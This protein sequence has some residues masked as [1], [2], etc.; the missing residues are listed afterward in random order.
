MAYNE[1]LHHAARRLYLMCRTP[2]EIADELSVPRRT[3]YSWVSKFNWAEQLQEFGLLESIDRRIQS[4]LTVNDKNSLQMKELELLIDRH[5]KLL[6]ARI[7]IQE[8]KES[9]APNA[10]AQP[11]HE[12]RERSKKKGRTHKNDVSHLTEADFQKGLDML[13]PFQRYVVDNR[14]QR[15]R[16]ILKSRQIGMTFTL[17]FEALMDA[18]LSGDPCIFLS[19]SRAQAEVF[20]TYIV[21]LA[22]QLFE[23]ELKGNPIELHT[24]KGKS[25]LRFLGTN[26]NT[27]HSYSGHLYTDEYFWIRSF[28]KIKKVSSGIATHKHWRLT[29]FSTPSS[30]EHEAYGFWTGDDWKG[31]DPK[32]K[33]I[34]F[35]SIEDYRDGGRLCP[36]GQWRYVITIEDAVAQGFDLV[37]IDTL[38]NE[39]S[40]LEY[41]NL[42]MCVFVSSK[43]AIF[44]FKKV[45]RCM[46]D[47]TLWPD[48]NAAASRPFADKEV[49]I[50]YDPSRT[51]DPASLVVVAPPTTPKK[52]FRLLKRTRLKGMSYKYQAAEIIKLCS[53]YNVRYIGIDTTGLGSAVYEIVY[54]K[55]P[56]ITHAIHYNVET[57][58][59]LVFKMVDLVDEK[60]IF[61]DADYKDISLSFL[62]IRRIVTRSGGSVTF[63]ANRTKDTGH[64]DDFFALAHACINEPLNNETERK[65]EWKIY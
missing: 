9:N 49:W 26:S 35:P 63:A 59:A 41:Q 43:D 15:I 34:A 17:A 61:W 28:E 13:Y 18:T 3:I 48:F 36:D 5:I 20:K 56:T 42:F 51:N 29:Y 50:G 27:A 21:K 40:E 12:P 7:K 37:D 24:A 52:P 32:R 39:R 25:V 19:A 46:T 54:D 14:H 45:M 57:K 58:N 8:A 64:A 11:P 30:E 33:H 44:E 65:S 62:A 2:D 38:K 47:S 31:T 1:E 22:W 16:N 23:I 4:L 60:R 55:F 6:A 53:V 10:L